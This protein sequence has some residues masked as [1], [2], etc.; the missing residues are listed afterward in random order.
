M[1]LRHC[2]PTSKRRKQRKPYFWSSMGT[3]EA[4]SKGMGW[5]SSG[6]VIWLARHVETSPAIV[7]HSSSS[8]SAYFAANDGRI[9]RKNGND[10]MTDKAGRNGAEKKNENKINYWYW[11][12]WM[13]SRIVRLKLHL[14]LAPDP[15]VSRHCPG[16]FCCASAWRASYSGHAQSPGNTFPASWRTYGPSPPHHVSK[17]CNKFR[18][19]DNLISNECNKS[20][21]FARSFFAE[22]LG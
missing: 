6:S 11:V 20:I 18:L 7:S 13:A 3:S 16:G 10:M 5:S 8:S 14:H 9:H 19:E 1:K 2:M 21:Y 17:L 4:A 22:L 15:F 12:H